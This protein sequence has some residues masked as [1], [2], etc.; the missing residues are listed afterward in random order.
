MKAILVDD[1]A[2]ALEFLELQVNKIGSIEVIGRFNNLVLEKNATLLEEVDVIFLDIEM[3]EINGLELAEKILEINADISIVFVTAFN[4]YAVRAFEL[5]A[6]DYV[7]KPIQLERLKKTLERVELKVNNRIHKPFIKNKMLRINV[8][9]ELR[10]EF[11]NGKP[12]FVQWRT[13]KSQELFLYLLHHRDKTI[14]KSELVELIWT[15]FEEDRAYSQLYTAIYHIR[16]IINK[17]SSHFKI[18]NMREGYVLSTKN[19]FIDLVKWEN[20]LK[21]AL[22]LNS[23]TIDRYE[24]IMKLYTGAYLQEYDYLW[25]E[26]ER[27]RLEQLW[28]KTAYQMAGYYDKQDNLEKAEAWYVKICTTSPEEE[29]A[30]FSL[31][32]LYGRLGFGLQINRQYH[33]LEKALDELSLEVSPSVTKWYKQWKKAKLN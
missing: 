19:V 5:N 7:L 32:K 25:V 2:L 6:L 15:D 26:A 29:D 9:R 20:K 22:P 11:I 18:E 33:Q 17:Y 13:T 10:F 14:R 28:L 4:D 24:E 3:P 16:K 31:M 1:E 8:S 30:H 27:Y 21:S 12:E 23:E